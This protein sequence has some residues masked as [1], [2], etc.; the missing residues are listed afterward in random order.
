M[1]A[2]P[3][4]PNPPRAKAAPRSTGAEEI[5]DVPV[6]EEEGGDN[7]PAVV[8]NSQHAGALE[9]VGTVGT[10]AEVLGKVNELLA[11]VM[12]PDVDYGVIPATGG[13]KSLYKPGAEKIARLFNLSPETERTE[14]SA[15]DNAGWSFGYRTIVHDPSGRP[16]GDREAFC[17]S[18]EK[19]RASNP[20]NTIAAM[21]Q[22]R[23]FSGAV[24]QS[25][26]LG[27]IF[28]SFDESVVPLNETQRAIVVRIYQRILPSAV[29][30]TR[31][32]AAKVTANQW[33]AFLGAAVDT[34]VGVHRWSEREGTKV[35]AAL[36]EPTAS[37]ADVDALVPEAGE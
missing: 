1:T 35:F 4:K 7:L 3:K 17:D 27:S 31:K 33:E 5:I 29:D 20:K 15:L 32:Q 11:T 14:M 30:R 10:V 23:A 34:A 8:S 36:V 2:L 18:T 25:L 9:M 12:V 21:A 19:G 13:K 37:V 28:A 6:I 24:I 22:K 26:G 16:L